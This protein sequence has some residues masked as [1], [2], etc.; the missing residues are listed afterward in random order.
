MQQNVNIFYD[1]YQV[2]Y[3]NEMIDLMLINLNHKFLNNKLLMLMQQFLCELLLLLHEQQKVSITVL[4]HQIFE[5]QFFE[6]YKKW[7]FHRQQKPILCGTFQI[8]RFLEVH[9]VREFFVCFEPVTT[10]MDFEGIKHAFAQR[11]A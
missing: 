11:I 7:F 3:P 1:S 10:T 2:I 5:K 8:E 4:F 6:S 9:G